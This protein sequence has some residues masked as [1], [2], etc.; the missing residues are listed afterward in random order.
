[1]TWQ[2]GSSRID[3]LLAEGRLEHVGGAATELIGRLTIDRA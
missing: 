2:R 1:M 3:E